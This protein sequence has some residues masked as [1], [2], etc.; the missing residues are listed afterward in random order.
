MVAAA[1][2]GVSLLIALMGLAAPWRNSSDTPALALVL[3]SI[4]M[5]VLAAAFAVAA[6]WR[7]RE[8]QRRAVVSLITCGL[9]SAAFFA[10]A[11]QLNALG[12][13]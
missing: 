9:A 13:P 6:F 1:F 10:L 8:L 4:P 12:G 3:L 11:L 7:P 5:L 2:G